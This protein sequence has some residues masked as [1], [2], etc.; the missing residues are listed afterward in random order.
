[1]G[2]ERLYYD[3]PMLRQFEAQVLG[4]ELF[5]VKP[6]AAT[7]ERK[8]W[9]ARLDRTAFYPTSGGQ[10]NDLGKLGDAEVLD[11]L[12]EGEDIVHVVDRPIALGPARGVIDWPRRFDHMQQHTGQHLLSAILQ[13]RFDLPTVSFHLGTTVSTIDLRG[14]EPRAELLEQAERAANEIIFEDR[15][16]TIRYGTVE[17]LAKLGV[18]KQVERQGVLRAIEIHGIDLQPCGGT[19]VGATGQIGMLL[20]RRCAKI[21]QDWR[22]E[23]L[24]GARAEKAARADRAVVRSAAES[25]KCAEDDVI[26]SVKRGVAE[27]EAQFKG[28]RATTER[29]AEAEARLALQEIGPAE[30]GTRIVARVLEGVE[31]VYLAKFATR[32]AQAEGTAALLA[33]KECGHLAFAQHPSVGKDMSALLKN[34]LEKLG[35]KGGGTRDFARGALAKAEDGQAA[36]DLARTLFVSGTR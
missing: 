16:V 34:V 28:L 10:P 5:T 26:E 11:V 20:I 22:V 7:V 19:H 35:G 23:F 13:A 36:I 27:R 33:R 32:I 2:T 3:E 1:M 24:C 9:A 21:R 12:D 18:R 8:T 14:P 4:C 6:D 31:P 15:P 25:L 17:E 29:L 30:N